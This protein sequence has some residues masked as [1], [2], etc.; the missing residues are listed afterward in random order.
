[1]NIYCLGSFP[2]SPHN[3]HLILQTITL[4]VG[5]IYSKLGNDSPLKNQLN[6]FTSSKCIFF[7]ETG[8]SFPQKALTHISESQNWL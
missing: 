5:S 8:L 1:M 3:L 4:S 2:I 6:I 7:L